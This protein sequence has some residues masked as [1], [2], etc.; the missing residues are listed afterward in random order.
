MNIIR[1]Q[2]WLVH[3]LVYLKA[4][5]HLHSNKLL[6]E[7][8]LKI[9]TVQIVKILSTT[10]LLADTLYRKWVFWNLKIKIRYEG[11]HL[12]FAP[13]CKSIKTIYSI[14]VCCRTTA[15]ESYKPQIFLYCRS[16]S[17]GFG[18]SNRQ[19]VTPYSIAA[20]TRVRDISILSTMHEK[21]NARENQQW[22]CFIVVINVLSFA[23][24]RL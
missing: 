4:I 12:K 11:L 5:K 19:S 2:I 10:R 7:C 15:R 3:S 9:Q 23:A 21:E 6:V 1:H 20:V 13:I 8:F 14:L 22:R 17:A 24:S 18:N 16:Y